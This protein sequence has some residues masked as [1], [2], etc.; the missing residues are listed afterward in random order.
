[1]QNAT[2]HLVQRI[3]NV[4]LRGQRIDVRL[5]KYFST[6]DS[7]RRPFCIYVVLHKYIPKCISV[8]RVVHSP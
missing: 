3:L 1:M 7:F 5:G 2:L 8:S 4:S 6:W